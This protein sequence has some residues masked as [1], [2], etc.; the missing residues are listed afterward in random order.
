MGRIATALSVDGLQRPQEPAD[1]FD[2]DD[3]VYIS[4][5]FRD[6]REGARLG[7]RWKSG[8]CGGE[9]ETGPQQPL[10]RGF[11]AFFVDETTCLGEHVVEITVDGAVA[12]VTS[13]MIAESS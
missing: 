6:V 2:L 8:S 9:Y 13:F 11:F 10:R 4:V 3:R 5:E 12:A 7:I 1:R